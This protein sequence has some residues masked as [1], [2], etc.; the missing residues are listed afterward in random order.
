V[1]K[2]PTLFLRDWD[3]NPRYVTREPNPDCAW[4]FD[5][6]GT[7]TVKWDGTCVMLDGQGRWWARR[8]VKSG[9]ADPP[10]FVLIEEDP[11]TGKRMGWEP[12]EQSSFARWHAEALSVEPKSVPGTFELLGPKVNGNP[13]RFGAHVLIRHGWAPLSI[14]EDVKAAPRD[15]DGLAAWLAKR[16][17]EGIVWHGPDGKMAKIKKRDFPA[18]QSGEA[19][20]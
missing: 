20:R 16:P 8:E 14:R 3:G 9:K 1:K 12:V 5:G 13:D 18:Q 4:V 15:Y 6:E 2:I 17:Y 19:A 7:P 10:N 11:E